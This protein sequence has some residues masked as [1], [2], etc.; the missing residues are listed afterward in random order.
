MVK[1]KF[2]VTSFNEKHDTQFTYESEDTRGTRIGGHK[3]QTKHGGVELY[4]ESSSLVQPGYAGRE[5]RIPMDFGL[6]E[7]VLEDH[8]RKDVEKVIFDSK[9]GEEL[10]EDVFSQIPP[11]S[12][13]ADLWIIDVDKFHLRNHLDNIGH[14][15]AVVSVEPETKENRFSDRTA[16]KA[17]AVTKKEA[18][19]KLKLPGA[20]LSSA[21]VYWETPITDEVIPLAEQA[22][23]LFFNIRDVV[24][25]DTFSCYSPELR[26]KI[27]RQL[28]NNT[29]AQPF[30]GGGQE[31]IEF[32]R[33][34][35]YDTKNVLADIVQAEQEVSDIVVKQEKSEILTGFEAWHR[36]GGKTDNGDGWVIRPDGTYREHDSDDVKRHKSDGNYLWELVEPEE[37]ALRWYC[38]HIKNIA[39]SDFEVVKHPVSGYTEAQLNAVA[40]IEEDIGAPKG[41]FNLREPNDTPEEVNNGTD[42]A[43]EL[44]KFNKAFGR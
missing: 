28:Q 13:E 37:A 30:D 7:D 15:Y 26:E 19:D 29:S 35:C 5:Y 18:A 21:V 23:Q 22:E 38:D 9:Y 31:H 32:V 39:E 3:W 14:G 25:A 6:N 41:A 11:F 1:I 20:S 33:D 42:L 12:Q 24:S 10:L 43:S 2:E 16:S 36:R 17:V 4:V 40:E 34:W 27:V 8:L 44:T